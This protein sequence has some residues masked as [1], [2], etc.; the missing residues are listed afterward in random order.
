MSIFTRSV[1]NV[2]I[3]LPNHCWECRI[4]DEIITHQI[5]YTHKRL[6]ELITRATFKGAISNN[7]RENVERLQLVPYILDEVFLISALYL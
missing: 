3:R 4:C 2:L 7:T 6:Q 1:K 5:P